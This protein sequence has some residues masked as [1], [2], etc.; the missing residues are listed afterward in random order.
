MGGTDGPAAGPSLGGRGDGGEGGGGAATPPGAVHGGSPS[1]APPDDGG[2]AAP[3]DHGDS[4]SAAPPGAWD[5]GDGGDDGVGVHGGSSAWVDGG[6]D[7]E[8][9]PGRGFTARRLKV[10]TTPGATSISAASL[11]M[12]TTRP[13]IPPAVITSSPTDS[14]RAADC[15]W[16]SRCWRGRMNRKYTTAKIATMTRRGATLE[17]LDFD[18]D[19]VVGDVLAAISWRRKCMRSTGPSPRVDR[20][21]LAQGL[22]APGFGH[23]HAEPVQAPALDG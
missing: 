11:S 12:A 19:V 10:I 1:A 16:R 15:C 4:P 7:V 23:F 20:S 14:C 8:E 13:Y 3:P 9:E 18:V 17:P 6:G 21:T 22:G 2:A 5:N